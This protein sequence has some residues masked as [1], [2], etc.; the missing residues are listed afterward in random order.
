[1][2]RGKKFLSM[3]LACATALS[4]SA[5]SGNT[6]ENMTAD[7]AVMTNK[8][9]ENT[10]STKK[11]SDIATNSDDPI[12]IG[13]MGWSSGPD[14]I[15]GLVPQYLLTDYFKEVNANGG[16]LGRPIDFRAYDVSGLDGDFSEAVNV[17]N[18]LIQSGVDIII[19]PSNST[20]S[21]AVAEIC[22]REGILHIPSGSAQLVTVDENGEARPW[23]FRSGPEASDMLVNLANYTYHELNDPKVAILYETTQIEC[24]NMRD[25][26]VETYEGLGGTVVGDATYQIN[27]QEF[28]A[29]L[30]SLAEKEPDY[31]FMPAMGYKEIGYVGNQL[32]ELGYADDIKVM[33]IQ[34]AYNADLLTLAGDALN[35]MIFTT[36]ADLDSERFSDISKK[37]Y[38]NYGNTG[39]ALHADGLVSFNEAKLAEYA[40][41][42][43]GS[44]DPEAMRK[45]LEDADLIELITCSINGY[46]DKHNVKGFVYNIM[47]V[48]D[49][50][51]MNLGEY[52]TP[53]Q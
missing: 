32:K 6:S 8:D 53:E 18:K 25:T 51:F 50:K 39:M 4:L 33:A 5:C 7:T 46:D 45:A 43:A 29:Q 36:P 44:T 19:G 14:S 3:I 30:R 28:R 42:T 49:G 9:Q 23:T 48:E 20:Q 34:I 17:A 13:F 37:Y 10:S 24:V 1:M 21:T 31:I 27:D 38:D 12:V 15:Y 41:N 16:W 2:R 47:T 22:N 52:A 40:V 35:G 26:F 11:G